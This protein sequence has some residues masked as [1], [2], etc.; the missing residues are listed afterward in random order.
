[1]PT[2]ESVS[3]SSTIDLSE[4]RVRHFRGSLH[5]VEGTVYEATF[6]EVLERGL[7][8][9]SA[10]GNLILAISVERGVVIPNGT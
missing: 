6:G 2:L 10:I 1:M 9:A 4:I 5:G 7:S 3:L 8:R